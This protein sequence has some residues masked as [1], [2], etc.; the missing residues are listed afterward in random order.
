MADIRG[1]TRRGEISR[2][3]L[4]A[5]QTLRNEIA[6]TVPALPL[7]CGLPT[8]TDSFAFG[9][10]APQDPD[11]CIMGRT[12]CAGILTRPIHLVVLNQMDI[13]LHLIFHRFYLYYH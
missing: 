7:I 4:T 3:L 11:V 12:R 13:I 8:P 2:A 6:A 1:R 5:Q 9:V 10:L